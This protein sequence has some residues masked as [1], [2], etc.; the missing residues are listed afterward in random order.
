MSTAASDDFGRL[1]EAEEEAGLAVLDLAGRIRLASPA[2]WA[3]CNGGTPPETGIAAT[4][5]FEAGTR[6]A[7]EAAIAAALAGP[8]APPTV[9][10]RLADLGLPPDAAVEVA[11]RPLRG[12]PGALLRVTDVTRR[13]RM[14]RQLEEGARLQM[15]GQLAGGMAHDFNNLLA[16]VTGAA[17]A[18]LGRGPEA[19]TQEDLRRILDAAA[20]G[21][22]L[23]RHLLAFASRQVLAPQVI[24]LGD[25]VAAME[26]L[27]MQLRGNRHGLVFDVPR[28]GPRVRVDLAQLDQVLVNL[29]VNAREAMAGGGA[30]RVALQEVALATEEVAQGSVIPAGRWAVLSVA[31]EGPGIP[32]EILSRIFEPFFT[33]RRGDG[34]TGLGLSTVLG[35]L[36]QSGGHVSVMP[37]VARGTVFRLWFPCAEG[38][39]AVAPVAAPAAPGLVAAPA[40]PGLVAAPAV[41]RLAAARRV[42]LVEDEAALRL[43]ARR[44]LTEAGHVV[45]VAEDAE[46]ALAAVEAGFR[47]DLL[48]SDV[49]MPGEM[50]GLGLA[51][52]LRARL[53]GLPV[54][55]VSGYAAA[56]VGEGLA[57]RGVRFLEK[58]FRMA[59]LVAAVAEAVEPAP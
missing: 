8:P 34:G 44:A 19:E 56:T 7:V 46:A 23:I 33:T 1:F 55:L 27:L 29:V 17:E 11:C 37:G 24:A 58:P 41:P 36:R 53:P 9:A 40:A 28:P 14:Q 26:P 49:T 57:G 6:A 21:A 16:A 42:L 47:P 30:I 45:E 13:R 12:E 38:A 4:L 43:L 54:I 10:A 35:I 50:D 48:V 52:A 5:L 31:D 51:E 18:A 22:R 59:E 2:L 32:P 15:V 39:V 20:R 3:L 25:A